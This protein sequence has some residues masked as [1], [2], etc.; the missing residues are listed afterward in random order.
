[1]MNKKLKDEKARIGGGHLSLRKETRIEGNLNLME[2]EAERGHTQKEHRLKV[3]MNI[4]GHQT[5][6]MKDRVQEG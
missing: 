6:R 1:M 3:R 2:T 4:T 5:K